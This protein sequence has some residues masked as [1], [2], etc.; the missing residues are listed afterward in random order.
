[1]NRP[2]LPEKT[3]VFIMLCDYSTI[4]S[5]RPPCKAEPGINRLAALVSYVINKDLLGKQTTYQSIRFSNSLQD[6]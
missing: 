2:L 3:G 1:M 4:Y 6:L 5:A